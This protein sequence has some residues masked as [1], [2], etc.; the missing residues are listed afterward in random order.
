MYG[1]TLLL[2]ASLAIS[3]FSAPIVIANAPSVGE[4]AVGHRSRAPEAILAK[5]ML[6]R[7]PVI[8]AIPQTAA[9][10]IIEGRDNEEE[11]EE[12]DLIDNSELFDDLQE[13]AVRGEPTG[14]HSSRG[15]RGTGPNPRGVRGT[16]HNPR[17]VRGTGPNPRGVRGT[18]HNPRG[19]RGTGHNPRGVRGTG[20]TPKRS[21][22]QRAYETMFAS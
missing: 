21:L 2:V 4:S 20:H 3:T 16:G 13:R 9:L 1:R 10:E 6:K 5:E 18:G 14:H 15:V 22:L 7:E 17:G 8:E 12:E 19:V 11:E